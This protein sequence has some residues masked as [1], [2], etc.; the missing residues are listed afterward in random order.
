MKPAPSI[1]GFTTLSG[2]GYG[3]L[4]VLALG[5]ITGLI[6]AERWFGVAGFVAALGTVTAG[7]LA[8]TLHLGHP[9]RAWRAI[10]QW[11]S[12][13]LSR[14]GLTAIA[15]YV[16]ACILAAGW[17]IS[18]SASGFFLGLMAILAAIGAVATVFCTGM[19]YASLLP[20]SAWHQP[21]TVP[22]YLAL[23]L[24]TGL[25]AVQALLALFGISPGILAFLALVVIVAT[26]ALKL[27]YWQMVSRSRSSAPSMESATG[28][29]SLGLVR[30]LDPPHTQTNYLLD[31]MGF[32]VGRKHART[33]RW[34]CGFFGLAVPL[35]STLLALFIDHWSATIFTLVAFVAG[36][37]GVLIER[38]LFFA[39]AEHTVT[40]YYGGT[41]AGAQFTSPQQK[42]TTSQTKPEAT[43]GATAESRRRR[44]PP[45]RRRTTAKAGGIDGATHQLP[46]VEDLGEQPSAGQG[47]EPVSGAKARRRARS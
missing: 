11:R 46:D 10:S 2:L 16:P 21:L 33:L 30:M 17:M 39:E 42:T 12:S 28:L 29:G 26:A 1:I 31:E 14:E 35:A 23:A 24:M 40:L 34:L 20:I 38:W 43:K 9:E 25:L 37:V 22:V 3:M 19:I 13:W 15:T 6:P 32:Q 41:G 7:L 5:G 47:Q 44:T 45:A 4:F 18:G 36:M 8:S 27:V